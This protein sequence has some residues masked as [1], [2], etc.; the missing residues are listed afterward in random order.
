VNFHVIAGLEKPGV[1]INAELSQGCPVP[2]QKR[3]NR[4]RAGLMQSGMHHDM[5]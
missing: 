4:R 5:G 2:V 3:L 1:K